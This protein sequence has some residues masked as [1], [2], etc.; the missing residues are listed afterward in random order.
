MELR[1]IETFLKVAELGSFSRA[2]ERLGYTQSAVTMQIKQLE[3]EVGAR[4]F[5]RVPRGA[6]LTDQGRAFAF[7]AREAIA[8]LERAAAS[9]R[10]PDADADQLVGTL[11]IG[12]VE[13]VATALLPTLL[14]RFHERHPRVELIVSTAR[15][16]RLAE[17]VLDNTLD[18]LL[19]MDRKLSIARLERTVLREEPIVF[20]ASLQ[21]AQQIGPVRI[22]ELA[23][24]P[25]VLTERGESYRHELECL[26]AERDEQLHPV[27]ETGNTETLVH[28]AEQGVGISFLPRFSVAHSLRRKSLVELACDIE[29]ISMWIQAFAHE[30]KPVSRAMAAFMEMLRVHFEYTA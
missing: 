14:A 24:L 27:V 20:A 15:L 5:D 16:E 9:V 8:A 11:R 30:A 19:T 10:I 12:S 26:L 13:S 7:H 2:A 29:P 25:L 6:R 23:G 4:L 18:V 28:L 21:M 1:Q 17:G 3:R 22:D